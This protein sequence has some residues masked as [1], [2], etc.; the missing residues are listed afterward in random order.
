M[1]NRE[2]FKTFIIG[3]VIAFILYFAFL[4]IQIEHVSLYKKY[5]RH[6]KE[7]SK[8]QLHIIYKST[9]YLKRTTDHI[10]VLTLLHMLLLCIYIYALF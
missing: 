7:K 1:Y 4:I 9:T 2:A 10:L 8:K 3:S 6:R 5:K